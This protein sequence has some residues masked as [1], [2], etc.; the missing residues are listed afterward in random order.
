MNDLLSAARPATWRHRPL[1]IL[2][3]TSTAVGG[4]WFY[5]QV[6]GLSAAGHQV[7]AVV[8]REGPLADKLRAAGGIRVEII[9]FGLSRRLGDLPK[10]AAGELSLARFIHRYRPDVIHAHLTVATLACRAASISCPRALRVSQV[11]GLVQ[12]RMPIFRQLEQVTLR[13]DDLVIGS[14]QAIADRY[15]AM[16]ARS[17]AVSYYGCDVHRFDPA[18][19]PQPFREEFGL[20][21]G[22]PAVGMVAYM[23]R[24]PLP[25]FKE[26]GVK[27]HEVF[28]DA[29]PL[30]L[31]R[32]PAARLF[33]VGDE[34][35][36]NGDYR[37]SLEARAAGL[38]VAD[39]LCFTGI[40]SDI[41]SVM[42]GLDVL[43]NPSMD[44]SACYT[45][46]EA[47]LMRKGV[48]AT[49]VGGLPD[50]VKHGETGLLV[51]AADPAALADAVIDLLTDPE[52]T[53]A[54]G[55]AGRELCL[56]QFDIKTTVSQVEELYRS[57]IASLPRW[58]RRSRTAVAA[59]GLA[60]VGK[61]LGD[62]RR[63]PYPVD[64]GDQRAEGGARYPLDLRPVSAAFRLDHEGI[65]VT[66]GSIGP[67]YHNP[68]SAC[69][70]ALGR[71]TQAL[72]A[73]GPDA[74]M[75]RGAALDGLLTQARHLRRSQDGNGG[76][77]YPVPAPRYRVEP[78][79]YSGMAQG[80]AVSVLLRAF[81]LTA[82]QSYL[83]AAD[84]AAIL[85]LCPIGAGGCADFD[86]LGRPFLEECPSDPPCHILNG[87]VFALFG[88]R[89]LD[90]RNGGDFSG[91]AARRLAA[92]LGEFDLGYWSRYDLRFTAPASHAYHCLHISLLTAAGRV[93]DDCRF[94]D[95]ARCWS[96]YLS[97]PGCRLRAMAGKARFVLSERRG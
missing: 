72:D 20:H 90:E 39:R 55:Q 43:V 66:R 75:I 70:Y 36:G 44:E 60:L 64:T 30:I 34:L 57:G 67:A 63:R 26:V 4:G 23:Y 13:R 29:A 87:A 82:E 83:D 19:S 81:D 7:C 59:S 80:L 54:L 91:P 12:F 11:P 96:Q 92:Q 15:Q 14:C 32:F 31:A 51:P 2:Q 93:L 6:T 22:T 1:R 78:G 52:R 41:S 65:I 18:T 77:R 25:D 69:L 3:V 84:A 48:V 49:N 62:L 86:Q 73:A 56:R 28:I 61:G 9:P 10:L 21:E 85:L 68:V 46:A 5:D 37:R 50:T 45:V 16:G 58:R 71:H 17:V 79:W 97:R 76:W 27:G 94:T 42:A 47:L 95:M 33:I 89:E 74:T 8:P 88:L 24:S 38:G 35:L 40:R 53:H